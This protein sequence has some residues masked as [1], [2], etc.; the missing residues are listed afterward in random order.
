M[1]NAGAISYHPQPATVAI[2]LDVVPMRMLWRLVTP[3][4][5][6]MRQELYAPTKFQYFNRGKL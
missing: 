1:G 2:L 3:V 4:Q 5:C 6:K